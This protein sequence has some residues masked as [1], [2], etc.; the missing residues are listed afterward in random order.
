MLQRTI[1]ID[2]WLGPM[3]LVSNPAYWRAHFLDPPNYSKDN[4][5]HRAENYIGSRNTI[6]KT[7]LVAWDDTSNLH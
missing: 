6:S 3:S 4:G 7:Q 2:A 1:T 5:C